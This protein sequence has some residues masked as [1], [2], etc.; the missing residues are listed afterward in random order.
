MP[1][2][3]VLACCATDRGRGPWEQWV[4]DTI[5]EVGWA[6]VGISGETPYAFTVGLWHSYEL[7]EL[8]MFGL[9]EQDMQVWLNSCVGLIR[10]RPVQIPDA[11][12]FGGVLERFPVQLRA[13]DPSWHRAL[14]APMG[15]YY[16]TSDVPVRQLVWPDREGR[17][18]WNPAATATCRERQPQTWVPVDKHTE[19]PWR[20]V[21]ELSANWP[22]QHLEPDTTVMAS[23]EIVAGT[24][25][26]V[27][28][29]HDADGGW[30]FLDERGYAD[31]ATGWVY[32]GE[33]FKSQPWLARFATMEPDRQSWLDE[34]GQWRVRRFSE[35]LEEAAAQAAAAAPASDA[36]GAAGATGPAHDGSAEAAASTN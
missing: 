1:S 27:A 8:A 13:V 33:L 21:G 6:V 19:G 7:P 22:F 34:D 9:R 18:P 16:G 36:A 11:E 24:L 32:F 26:I 35:A 12:P 25:P 4:H 3:T 15:A 10:D 30:D 28:V 2:H 29:T 23:P 31:D 17:W 14:F 20:L 5:V